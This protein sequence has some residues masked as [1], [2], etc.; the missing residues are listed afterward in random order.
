VAFVPGG[1][2]LIEQMRG[3]AV[4]IVEAHTVDE[5]R[6][7]LTTHRVVLIICNMR[8]DESRM[9]DLLRLVKADPATSA[10]PFL[11]VRLYKGV[12]T[13]LLVESVHMACT[14]LGAQ[15]FIDLC[16][17]QEQCG[18]VEAEERFRQIVATHLTRL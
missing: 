15:A 9:L 5:A 8:F 1:M 11:C 6:A 7:L 12:L 16:A 2:R 14:A 18:S 4:Q 10:I 17:L 13:P 3:T